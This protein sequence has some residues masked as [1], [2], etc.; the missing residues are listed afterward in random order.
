[1]SK[2]ADKCSAFFKT[3][4]QTKFEWTV[5]V[6]EF[7][8]ELKEKLASMPKLLSPIN[9]ETLVLYVSVSNYSLSGVLIAEKE[10]K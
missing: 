3:L 9:K 10:K 4:K 1:M 2:S 8:D 6:E 5:E 7:F